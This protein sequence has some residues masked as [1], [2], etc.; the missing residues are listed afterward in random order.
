MLGLA[1]HMDGARLA[2]AIA[3]LACSPAE[4]TSK[5][6]VDILSFGASK[7]GALCAEAVVIFNSAYVQQFERR[8]KQGGHLWSKHRFLSAQ[9]I[10]YL[11]DGL[12][13]D[14][15]RHANGLASR[16]AQG[17]RGMTSVEILFPVQAN[18]VFVALPEFVVSGLEARGFK[19]YRWPACTPAKGVTIRLVTSYV[20]SVEEVEGLLR[21]TRKLFEESR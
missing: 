6:G 15:A 10:A 12:W 16:L 13:L 4:L 19:F 3:H 21:A 18:E 8:R 14:N 1:V 9:W 20:T 2:N 7:N 17:F 11:R 5:V